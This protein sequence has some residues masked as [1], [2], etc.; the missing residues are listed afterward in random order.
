[1]HREV[2]VQEMRKAF[3]KKK[4]P[5]GLLA[6]NSVSSALNDCGVAI[7]EKNCVV[8]KGKA[9]EFKMP[10]GDVDFD[11]FVEVVDVLRSIRVAEGRRRAGFST[12]EIDR[13]R[14][15]FSDYD[16]DHSGS[17]DAKEVANLLVDLGFKLRTKEE[18]DNVLA[19]VDKA[20]EA[21]AM[22]GVMDVGDPGHG[23]VSFWV[24]IQLL[25]VLYNRD[26]KRV[27][28]REAHAAEQSRFSTHEIEEFREVFL[29]WWAHEKN[30]EDEEEAN[31]P[32][33]HAHEEPEVDPEV[34]EISKDGMRRLLRQLGCNLS[35]DQRV[36]LENKVSELDQVNHHGVAHVDFAS[37]LRLM[38][39][40][41]DSNF[42]DINK[43]CALGGKGG[44][45]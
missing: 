39:W 24:L 18:R 37:F 35:H 33:Q 34:K 15:M 6:A 3:D 14:K 44:G 31:A 4:E 26:D 1:V 40:M 22:V 23:T 7:P 19:Q 16:A 8:L 17:I 11:S 20:R 28:D 41:L 5:S 27:L 13:F 12:T 10:E 32:G 9:T 43:H 2:E 25:R 30:F 36:E 29:N 21:A 38:R 42:A 45:H